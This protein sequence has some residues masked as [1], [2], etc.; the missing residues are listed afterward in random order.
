MPSI[1]IN[2]FGGMAPRLSRALGSN[3][4]AEIAENV[5]LGHGTLKPW[6]IPSELFSDEEGKCVKVLHEY[7]CCW[8]TDENPCATFANGHEGC[9]RVFGFGVTGYDY[10]VWA[11]I[12]KCCGTD[13]IQPDWKRLGVPQPRFSLSFLTPP[14]QA[15]RVAPAKGEQRKRE[16]RDYIYTYVN[17]CGEESAPSPA[18]SDCRDADADAQ[19]QLT[20]PPLPADAGDYDITSIR[21]YRIQT[22]TDDTGDK[23][24]MNAEYFLVDEID[25]TGATAGVTRINYTDEGRVDC[26]G[27]PNLTRHYYPPVECLQNVIALRDGVLMA[28]EGKKLWFS[29][30]WNY[31]AWCCFVEL[32]DVIQNI[33]YN[34]GN[35]D[36][37]VYVVTDGHP[38]IVAEKG[39]DAD[40]RCCRDVFKFP[41]SLPCVSVRSVAECPAG[42]V[43]ASRDGLVMLSGQ[44]AIVETDP[45]MFKDDWEEYH[46]NEIMGVIHDNVYFGF[47]DHQ[48][49]R[50]E[51][52]GQVYHRGGVGIENRFTELTLTPSAAYRSRDDFLYLAFGNSIGKWDDGADLLTMRWRQRISVMPGKTN[53]AASKVV[54]EDFLEHCDA[55]QKNIVRHYAGD[56]VFFEREL[57]H[58]RGYRLPRGHHHINFAVEIEGQEEVRE[59][60]FATSMHELTE[61]SS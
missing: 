13:I 38:Y 19:A 59:I 11:K 1:Q 54:F 24:G 32:D 44:S 7:Q 16:L 27:E 49:F 6:R 36:G 56:H 12:E 35:G 45:I 51:L 34:D 42:V 52:S 30:P 5:N 15:G 58:T 41:E 50:Y 3:S 25:V 53:F 10:P 61:T 46:P 2:T 55:P 20:I 8:I 9:N 40:C 17:S 31:H 28:H 18:V 48:S 21:I 47:S 60:H 39:I 33:S 14:N 37:A 29:E 26:L 4:R 43:Y 22:G 23:T 57:T